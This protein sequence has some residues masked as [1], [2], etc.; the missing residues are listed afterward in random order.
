MITRRPA[1]ALP[2]VRDSD[3]SETGVVEMEL[4]CPQTQVAAF[5]KVV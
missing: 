1:V 2:K 5:R 3:I 4:L